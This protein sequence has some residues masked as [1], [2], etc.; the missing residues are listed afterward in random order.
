MGTA[1]PPPPTRR[2]RPGGRTRSGGGPTGTVYTYGHSWVV[3]EV[4]AARTAEKEAAFFLPH[5]RPGM[6]VLDLGCGP[7]TITLG[8][9]TAVAPG[10]V[11]GLDIA[12]SVL[13]QARR[14]AGDRRV[15]NAGFLTGQAAAVSFR[16]GWF[17]AVFAHTLLEH[18]ADPVAV[19]RGARRVLKP[20]GLLGVRDCDWGSGVFAPP[21]PAVEFA[22]SLYAR[23][24]RHNGG[25]PD[26]GR[27]LRALLRAAGFARVQTSA[28]FRWDGSQ[29]GS[30]GDSR[31]VG[32]LLAERLLLPNF[33]DPIRAMGWGDAAL[34]ERTAAACRAWGRTP[35][36]FATMVMAEAIGWAE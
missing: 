4:H 14:L 5:L 20:G 36:A 18:V 30:T 35:D 22:A 29:D 2:A 32:D 3:T 10:A 15:A 7:G 28:S 23:V 9:A 12:A 16:D 24:W 6:R 27:R 21:D 31:S 13:G 17:D 19:L 1:T 25:D 33:A 11:L 34:L 8:L 26:C